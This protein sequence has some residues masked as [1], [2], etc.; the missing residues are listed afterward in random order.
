MRVVLVGILL[1][2]DP[3]LNVAIVFIEKVHAKVGVV[4]LIV[5]IDDMLQGLPVALRII[6]VVGFLLGEVFI[7]AIPHGRGE[8][9]RD[10]QRD[11]IGI[12]TLH[13]LLHILEDLIEHDGIR[14]RRSSQKGIEPAFRR[15]DIVVVKDMLY[16]LVLTQ[17]F[18]DRSPIRIRIPVMLDL[19]TQNVIV[20][21]GVCDGILMQT[22]LEDVLRGDI[23]SLLAVHTRITAVLLEDRSSREAEE[24]SLGEEVPDSSMILPEL[25]AVALI[26]D[27]DDTFVLQSLQALIKPV[28]IGRIQSDSQFLDSGNDHLVGIVGAL[29]AADQSCRVHVLLNASFLELV[30]LVTGLFVQVL[31]VDKHALFNA[32]IKLE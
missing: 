29:Q 15:K 32:A 17:R 28:L 6:L 10:I 18:V 24:L 16:D 7:R 27:E 4:P 11:I 30:E 25:A 8:Y 5:L 21:D 2:L 1:V 3:P 12:L 31:S 26:E 20:R 22:F 13:H 23:L 19:E 9:G 14:D